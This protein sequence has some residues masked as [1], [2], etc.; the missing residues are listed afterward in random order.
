MGFFANVFTNNDE[1]DS[2]LLV[3]AAL[4]M[5]FLHGVAMIYFP[6]N[7]RK[8]LHPTRWVHS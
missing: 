7:L 2:T 5:W 8:R 4:G 6:L 1:L 3:A